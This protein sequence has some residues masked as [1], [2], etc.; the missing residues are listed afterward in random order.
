MNTHLLLQ[1]PFHHPV[2]MQ[3]GLAVRFSRLVLES[4]HQLFGNLH[5]VVEVRIDA[6][7]LHRVQECS[8][9]YADADTIGEAEVV[10]VLRD[11][12]QHSEPCTIEA[13]GFHQLVITTDAEAA[14]N[15]S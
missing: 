14:W 7:D 5:D 11:G 15:I 10:F 8:A 2:I 3:A 12:R 13:K 6:V 4:L 1:T 9:S